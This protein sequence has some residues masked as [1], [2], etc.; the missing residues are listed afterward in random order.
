[1]GALDDAI[2]VLG[3]FSFDEPA[4]SQ[5]EL[6]RRLGRPKATVSRVMR[7]LRETGILEF[8]SE[9]R[10][11]S[12]GIR[13][14]ELGQISQ[15]NHHFLDLVHKRLQDICDIGGHTGYI[16]VFD[17]ADLIVLRVVRG[18]SPL[19]IATSPGYKTAAY[20]TSNG[21]AMLALLE[22]QAWRQRV[23]DPIPY[24]S[25]TTPADHAELRERIGKIRAS[26]RSYSSNETVEGVSSQGT[27]MRD[28][29]TQEIIGVAISYPASLGTDVLKE[30]IA[31]LLDQ[32]RTDL[33]R[34]TVLSRRAAT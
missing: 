26:G 23:P 8:D 29:D 34:R 11:Y 4:L 10:L 7:S 13:L 20:A 6:T 15:A 3:C 33:M 12:P 24:V 30:R 14:F 25:A 18:S 27:A 2:S 5:A 28:P 22:D 17:G 19:A 16:T 32:M 21:R 9:R 1:M 31:V